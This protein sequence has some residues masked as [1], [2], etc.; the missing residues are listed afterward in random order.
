MDEQSKNWLRGCAIGCGTI[1]LAAAVLGSVGLLHVV[2]PFRGAVGAQTVLEARVGTEAGF[3]P[4]ADGTI[5]PDRIEA[6]LRVRGGLG[7]LCDRFAVAGSSV[8]RLE[9]LDREQDPP[10][11]E[12]LRRAASATSAMFEMAPLMGELFERRNLLLLDADMNL[13]EYSYL[14]VLAY[15]GPLAEDGPRTGIL[16]GSPVN[17]RIHG[18]LEQTLVRQ[19]EAARTESS[20]ADWIASLERETAAMAADPSRIPWQDGLPESVLSSLEPYRVPLDAA[21]C[22]AA[23]QVELLRTV[24]RGLSFESE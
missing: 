13:G 21:F 23:A 16:D 11:R 14:Y 3:T 19:L 18:L 15:H 22:D 8:A 5:A 24:R 6:F 17:P 12:I 1:L 7:A 9:A 10:R 4:A 20:D 2:R